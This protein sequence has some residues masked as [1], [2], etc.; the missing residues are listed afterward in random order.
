MQL[1]QTIPVSLFNNHDRRVRNIDP[2]LYL[3][4]IGRPKEKGIGIG[5]FVERL[6]EECPDLIL[7]YFNRPRSRF[8]KKISK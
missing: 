4:A 2:D 1:A 3:D 6:K 7:G 8:S 5:A